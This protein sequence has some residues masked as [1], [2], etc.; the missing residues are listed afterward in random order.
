MPTGGQPASGIEEGTSIMVFGFALVS[1]AN[2]S[3]Y[4]KGNYGG[5]ASSSFLL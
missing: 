3:K 2:G 4:K 5:L 1:T